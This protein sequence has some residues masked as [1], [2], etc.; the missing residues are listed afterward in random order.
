VGK[1]KKVKAKLATKAH[2][3]ARIEHALVALVAGGAASGTHV[4]EWVGNC[5]LVGVIALAMLAENEA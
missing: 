4:L 5:G 1:L 3:I 2:T